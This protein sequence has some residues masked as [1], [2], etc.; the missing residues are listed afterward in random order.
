[1]LHSLPG[2]FESNAKK[3]LKSI[4]YNLV[5]SNLGKHLNRSLKTILTDNILQHFEMKVCL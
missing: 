4:I 3:N 1:M 5:I 2:A